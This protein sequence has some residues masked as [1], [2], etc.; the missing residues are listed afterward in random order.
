MG[1]SNRTNKAGTL[2][3]AV[4]FFLLISVSLLIS[5]DNLTGS[6][7]GDPSE[8]TEK[9]ESS[10]ASPSGLAVS[11]T[12]TENSITLSWNPVKGAISYCLYS[13]ATETGSYVKVG[14]GTTE[15]NQTVS[16]L[17][18]ETTFYFKVSSVNAKGEGEKSKAVSA[19]TAKAVPKYKNG[20]PEPVGSG[21]YYWSA[22][23]SVLI[24]FD[25][26]TGTCIYTSYSIQYTGTY[27]YSSANG[28]KFD[29]SSTQPIGNYTYTSRLVCT[30]P[31]AF[32]YDNGAKLSLINSKK[33][34]G[35]IGVIP[36][37][38][39][40]KYSTETY[41]TYSAGSPY[42]DSYTY[43]PTEGYSEYFADGTGV[44]KISGNDYKFTWTEDANGTVDMTYD[45]NSL[46]LTTGKWTP[47]WFMVNGSIIESTDEYVYLKQ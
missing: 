41:I 40:S 38:Y 36:G 30:Y 43:S 9:P 15:T 46:S 16:S 2:L 42:T 18:S 35:A 45:T 14:T 8:E 11:G 10:I 39:E 44:A 19:A 33:T 1:K 4:A 5:C 13:S 6:D 24:T 12:P 3:Y 32:C 34:S 27:T 28:L 17:A 23:P 26:A 47:T 31:D 29:V 22:Y 20:T 37:T 7:G 25:A 21:T